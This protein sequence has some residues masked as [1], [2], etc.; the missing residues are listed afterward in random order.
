MKSPQFKTNL[1][2]EKANLLMQ[3]VYI[4]VVDNIRKQAEINNWDVTYKEIN[5]PFPS[6]ILTQKKR[7]IVKETNVWF[8]C[9]QVCFKEFTT[10]KNE[11]VEID[12]MLVNDSG[13]LNWDEIEKKTQLIVSSFFSDN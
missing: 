1:D 4:R 10:E 11:P 7:D 5:E 3:P 2:Y 13:E 8:I 12:S 6:H 9:F